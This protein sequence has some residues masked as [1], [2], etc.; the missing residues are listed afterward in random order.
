MVE[1]LS[2]KGTVSVACGGHHSLFVQPSGA[3]YACGRGD[4]GQL[5]LA[6]DEKRDLSAVNAEDLKFSRIWLHGFKYEFLKEDGTI[7]WTAKSP[8]P[9][10]IV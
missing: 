9:S 7:E 1:G 10:W 4:R 3:V 8:E 5:G 2:G 6:F